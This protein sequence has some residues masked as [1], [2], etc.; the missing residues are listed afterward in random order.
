MK[1][2]RNIASRVG[3]TVGMPCTD[4]VQGDLVSFACGNKVKV[5]KVAEAEAQVP[6]DL[7][8]SLVR[9]FMLDDV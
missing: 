4:D 9:H 6:A 1:L 2:F 5:M 8:R 7:T 3:E